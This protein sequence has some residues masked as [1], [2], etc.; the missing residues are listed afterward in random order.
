VLSLG[1]LELTGLRPTY[2]DVEPGQPAMLAGSGDRVEVA[3]RDGSA[4]DRFGLVRGQTLRI[5]RR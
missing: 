2:S 3:V 4:A 5:E 1:R